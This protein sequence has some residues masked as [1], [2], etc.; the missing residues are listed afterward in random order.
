MNDS[1]FSA[2]SLFNDGWKFKLIDDNDDK[3]TCAQ[4]L[5]EPN[6]FNVE[7]PHDWLICNPT[8]KFYESGTGCYRKDF[9]LSESDLNGKTFITFDG[10]YMNSTVFVNGV[11]VGSWKYGYSSFTFDIS[12]AVVSG[13]NTIL[14]KVRHEA[15]NTRWYSGA[16][17]YRN[18]WLKK[19]AKSYIAQDGVY[20]S[21]KKNESGWTIFIDTEIVTDEPVNLTNCL[22]NADFEYVDKDYD[23]NVGSGKIEETIRISEPHLW[24]VDDPY[25]YILRTD[26]YKNGELYDRVYTKFGFKTIEF[27]PENGFILNGRSLKLHGVCMHHDLGALGA[28]QNKK[29]LERQ[30][31]IL[32][33]F[34]VNSIRTSHNMPASEL[35][36]ICDRLGILVNSESFDMWELPKNSK[37]YAR[38]FPE[39]YKTD[40]ASWVRRDCNHASLIMWSIGN[41][42][43]DTHQSER[44]LEVAKML[45]TAVREND[46]RG[47]AACTIG[48]NYMPWQ[49]AQNVADYLK[50]A[51]YNY[52]ENLYDEHHEKHPDW[53][54]Y[55]SETASTVRSRGIYHL[56][57]DVP[58]LTHD[59]L[60]CSDM[61]N[62][63]VGWGRSHES[64]WVMDRDRKYCGGQ[65]IWTGFD[66]IGEPTPYSTKNSYFGIVDT[67]GLPKDAYYLYKA[68]WTNVETAPFVHIMP[69][70]DWNEGDDVDVFVYSNAEDIELFFNG[71]SLGKQ[72]IDL[73]NDTV[74]HAAYKLKYQKGML[75]AVA[76]YDGKIV[77][78]TEISSFGEPVKI[79][80][81]P[82]STELFADARDLIFIDV[83]VA[84]KDGI[85]VANARN[86]ISVN[87]TG[88][89]RLVG[90]DNGDSTDYDSYK[91]HSRRLFSGRLVAIIQATDQSGDIK[92]ELTSKGLQS[93]AL[94][95]KALPAEIIS[96]TSYVTENVYPAYVQP[97]SDEIPAR[98]IELSATSRELNEKNK[99]VIVKPKILPENATYTDIT[100]K[101]VLDNGVET[102]IATAE[103]LDDGVKVTAHGDGKFRLRALLKNG[104]PNFDIVSDLAFTVT[105]LGEAIRSPYKFSSA[106][107]YNFSNHPLNVVERGAVSGIRERTV[108]GFTNVDFG[109]IGSDILQLHVGNSA[110]E[111]IEIEIWLGDPDNGGEKITNVEFAFNGLW[112]RFAPTEFVLPRRIKGVQSIAFVL[113]KHCIFGGFDFVEK[114]KAF[115]KLQATDNDELYGD[116]YAVNGNKI[117]KIGNNVV[118]GFTNMDFADGATKIIIAGKTPNSSNTIQLRYTPEGGSQQTQL[119]E[120]K[121]SSDYEEQSFTLEKIS[122]KCNISFVFLPGSNFDFDYFIFEK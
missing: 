83:E 79:V 28:A 33:S 119:L 3:L 87:V 58:I 16:G 38:F 12:E 26:I 112:D 111:P 91:G 105:G 63:V 121:K 35:M 104:K 110:N 55:G 54:I 115:E 97:D 92:V 117:E 30:V 21:P 7:I 118:I 71:N 77:A 57:A 99:T 48:S 101:C 89:G 75:K 120:F 4:I 11:N 116:D 8:N 98:K 60:Q 72:H 90:L 49:N 44:G 37:D 96:G 85:F 15:P 47:N 51:G 94:T 68:V 69:H 64:A 76:Y 13:N 32:K 113:Y 41:E 74:L 53:F 106:S 29:A 52:A 42:I 40:V 93:A 31:N 82:E 86:R 18:V 80:A 17:I 14:V 62:S 122:G 6:W 78:E 100:Y 27:S 50:L 81:K 65:Y 24:D 108:I 45:A 39:W 43:H 10:V 25:L 22:Y 109:K 20:I 5:E 84:D 73:L 34:G 9:C 1:T 114:S 103:K 61:G 107:L 2:T 95:L 67:A 70:W 88:A 19:C 59:D 66:Y 56:P 23:D 36:E 46:Y 102:N